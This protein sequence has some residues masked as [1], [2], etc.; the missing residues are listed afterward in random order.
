MQ[1]LNVATNVVLF[2]ILAPHYGYY[3][4]LSAFC[5]A[6]LASSGLSVWYQWKI[7]HSLP[8]SPIKFGVTILKL[9]VVLILVN[10]LFLFV[11][12][13]PW[14]RVTLMSVGNVIAV[15]LLFRWLK[16]ITTDDVERYVGRNNQV[17]L[18]LEKLLVQGA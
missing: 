1:T 13:P 3:G 7:L 17:G 2:L 8:F 16:I 5:L 10:I 4:A 11:I 12:D 6:V 18:A 15:V 9:G 14:Q